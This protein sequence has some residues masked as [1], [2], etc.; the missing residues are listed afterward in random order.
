MPDRTYHGHIECHEPPANGFVFAAGLIALAVGV[1][2]LHNQ[3]ASTFSHIIR[4]CIG[5][6]LTTDEM[7]VCLFNLTTMCRDR[8][9]RE[10]AKSNRTG[11]ASKE[12]CL[13]K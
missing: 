8:I 3:F 4:S 2:L 13:S 9:D 1:D 11:N 7:I 5:I 6:A 12:K 10:P